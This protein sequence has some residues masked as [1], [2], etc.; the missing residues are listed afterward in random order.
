M[1]RS[2]GKHGK[3]SDVRA[4]LGEWSRTEHGSSVV[5]LGDNIY[6]DGLIE[7]EREQAER[8]LAQQLAATPAMKVVLPGNHDWGMDPA[9]QNITAIRNQQT[10]IDEW[11]QG[12]AHFAPRD[13]C[14]GPE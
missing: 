2:K 12:N 9:R 3:C 8:I 5:F 7:E 4:A 1:C 6:D 10:F 11:P 14:L 13:G